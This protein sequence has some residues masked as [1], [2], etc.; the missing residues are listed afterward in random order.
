MSGHEARRADQL[1]RDSVLTLLSDDEVARVSTAES[2]LRLWDGD[3]YVDL[4]RLNLGVL[5]AVG[6]T[7]LMGRVLPRKSV[8]E[9]TWTKILALLAPAGTPSPTG[10]P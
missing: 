1:T 4:G 10:S 9:T 5:R 7:T 6:M 2:E 8:R 3:E